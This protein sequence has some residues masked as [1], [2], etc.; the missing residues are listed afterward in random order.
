MVAQGPSV[1]I[2]Y[3]KGLKNKQDDY[4]LAQKLRNELFRPGITVDVKT[5]DDSISSQGYQWL[6]FVYNNEVI[7][8][9][10]NEMIDSALKQVVK[11]QMQGL[12]AVTNTP[13]EPIGSW[14]TIPLYYATNEKEKE[15]VARDIMW[16]MSYVK[17]PYV[18]PKPSVVR[19]GALQVL[20][21]GKN[22]PR[23]AFLL[24][25]VLPL[26]LV[27][28]VLTG[29]FAF[30]FFTH[31]SQSSLNRQ[32]SMS[33]TA[34]A[35]AR[36]QA[37]LTPKASPQ[38]TANPV[39]LQQQYDAIVRGDPTIGLLPDLQQWDSIADLCV[40]DNNVYHV[41]IDQP[42]QYMLCTTQK[43]DL[44]LTRFVYQVIMK[45]DG[46]AGGVIFG[47]HNNNNNNP[48]YYR[49]DI[50]SSTDGND[51]LSVKYCSPVSVPPHSCA[52]KNTTDGQLLTSPK[53]SVK[54][55]P[56]QAVTLA[57]MVNDDKSIAL[58]VQGQ[59]AVSV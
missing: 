55:N 48:S 42:D 7:G 52:D 3:H 43:P 23:G 14:K 17:Q 35:Q 21:G 28:L 45:I 58:Y 5:Y 27:F 38:P 24:K 49:A 31:S 25:I 33:A 53:E 26:A 50:A 9:P 30:P 59:Y 32:S 46:S 44:N 54:V 19:N 34:T 47:Y 41:K 40:L 56:Q 20:S 37:T 13:T 1:L 10:G 11:R 16:A 36:V 39:A 12:L 4:V 15:K 57:V 29:Y 6:I 18:T 51:H 8:T 22:S 2:S